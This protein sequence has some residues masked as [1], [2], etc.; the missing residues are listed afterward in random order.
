MV[1]AWSLLYDEINGTMDETYPIKKKNMKNN[2]V[3]VLGGDGNR[4]TPQ[5]S[6]EYDPITTSNSSENITFKLDKR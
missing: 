1:N 3:T 2:D 5:E 6:D 4:I